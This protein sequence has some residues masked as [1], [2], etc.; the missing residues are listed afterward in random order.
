MPDAFLDSSILIGLHFRHAGERTACLKCLPKGGQLIASRYAVFEIARGFLRS[1]INLHNFSIDYDRLSDILLAAHTGQ[2][3]YRPYQM[4]TWLGCITDFIAAMEEDGG[5]FTDEQRLDLFRA[6]LRSVIDLG[7]QRLNS[8]YQLLNVAG[9]RDALPEP[10]LNADGL[11]IH[12]IPVSECGKVNACG[13]RRYLETNRTTVEGLINH[14]KTLKK[15]Q[16]PGASDK[17]AE[18]LGLI[19]ANALNQDFDGKSCHVC[20]DALLCLEA[21]TQ[22]TVATKNEKDF[23]PILNHLGKVM[24]VAETAKSTRGQASHKNP[25]FIKRVTS[26]ILK[27]LSGG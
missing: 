25:G 6:Q 3:R 12:S 13:V 11:V 23:R 18:H 2:V 8:S 22:S 16:K 7:W 21:P 9:C 15:R 19:L 27:W 5:A 26:R 24:V 4:A 20:G 17:H 10:T 1:L 14:I